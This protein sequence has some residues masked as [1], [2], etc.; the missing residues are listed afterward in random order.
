MTV[1]TIGN[2]SVQQYPTA[3][4]VKY[5]NVADLVTLLPDNDPTKAFTMPL[6]VA[7]VFVADLAE[8]ILPSSP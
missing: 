1:T 6:A 4:T 3:V 8:A 2:Y 5:D 7:Q